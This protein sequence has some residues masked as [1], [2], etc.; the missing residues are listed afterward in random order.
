MPNKYRLEWDNQTIDYPIEQFNWKDIW[1]TIAQEKYP[2]LKSFEELH[3]HLEQTDI[4]EL[5]YH[6]QKACQRDDMLEKIDA[7][8]S[9]ILYDRTDLEW[10]VQRTF[11]IRIVTPDQENNGRLLG[12]HK[13]A[14]TGNGPG[15]KNVWTPITDSFDT[16][17]M[18]VISQADSNVISKTIVDESLTTDATQELCMQSSKPL[19]IK[20]GQTYF[21]DSNIIHG[22]FNNTTDQTRVSMDGRILLKG[23][24]FNRKLPGGYFRFLGERNKE[25]ELNDDK[26]WVTYAGW[27]SKYTKDIPIHLQRMFVNNFC[28][29]KQININDYQ[30]ESDTLDWQPNF[31]SY[32]LSESINGIVC[33]SVFG[34]PD[35]PFR[36]MKLLQDAVQHKTELVFA[37]ENIICKSLEDIEHIK[38]LY[39]FYMMGQ[40]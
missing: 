7:Y 5:I 18:Y 19:N 29:Q 6:L 27:N 21:F 25:I 22:N 39:E 9:H 8:Y 35:D 31:E 12:F 37:N 11:N 15:I 32:I 4:P 34:L 36:R 1:L 17:S 2:H 3:I 14:W 33:Y 28:E 26:V 38:R 40:A 24:S 20:Q 30:Y 23:G 13:D 16:N 10:M